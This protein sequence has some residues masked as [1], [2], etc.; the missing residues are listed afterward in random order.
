MKEFKKLDFI[1]IVSDN[2]RFPLR[3]KELLS[4]DENDLM[5]ALQNSP[6]M[7][8]YIAVLR[9]KLVR[10]LSDLEL[11]YKREYSEKYILLKEDPNWDKNPTEK[12]L[13]SLLLMDD[14][15]ISLKKSIISLTESINII[16]GLLEGLKQKTILMQTLSANL[17]NIN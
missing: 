17:R 9:A 16:E 12:H 10:N 15:L 6:T 7:Y 1:E 4:I 5:N 13:E 2:N 8:G 3:I 14:A 11:K